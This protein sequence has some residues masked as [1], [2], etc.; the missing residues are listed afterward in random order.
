MTISFTQAK[1]FFS[2][3][4]EQN[5]I[6][7]LARRVRP[8][9]THQAPHIPGGAE[10]SMEALE[11][12]WQLLS[13]TQNNRDQL[14]DPQTRAQ[15]EH[16]KHNI[17]HFVGT[18]K[19]P[20][21]IAGPLRVN[22]VFAQGDYYLPLAT[23]EASLVASYS[24]G[25]VLISEAGGASVAVLNEG[26]GRSPVFSFRNLEELGRFVSWILTNEEQLEQVANATTLHGKLI[27]LQ[28][29]IEGTNVF[30]LFVYH[31]GDAAGQNMVTFA[32]D[33]AVRWINEH[34]PVKPRSVYLEANF[35][36]DKK[37][38]VQSFQSVRGKKVTAEISLPREMIEHYLHTTPERMLDYARLA[39]NGSTLSGTLGTQ[40]HYANG[41]A[42][43][44]IACG[45]DVAC[46]A[47]AAVGITDFFPTED[48]GLHASVMMPNLIVGTVGGGTS[49]PSQRAALEI[50]GLAGTGHA[51]A[52]A[53]VTA[54]LCLAGE[55]SLIGAICAGDFASAHARLARGAS[56]RDSAEP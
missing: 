11:Q 21:G 2:Q 45:Q 46:V 20:I 16:Y 51:N 4:L 25:S 23:T 53:E 35:S 12:R 29:S 26:V 56:P 34:T 52:L 27:D 28:L 42:A 49:L 41:L 24:R 18:V 44:F 48:G 6:E 39:T 17:E 8:K 7:E 50:A 5:G 15:M 3:L 32:T 13:A 9:Y 14:Y 47:E 55:L 22:G 54:C 30:F 40:A 10:I 1:L 43:L 33:A 36:G 37:A 31:T 19:V 38:S